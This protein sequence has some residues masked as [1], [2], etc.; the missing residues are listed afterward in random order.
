MSRVFPVRKSYWHYFLPLLILL[1]LTLPSLGPLLAPGLFLTQDGNNLLIRFAQFHLA[2]R[3]GQIPPRWA[4]TLNQG[5][6]YPVLIFYYPGSY[7]ASEVFHLVGF[8][9][10][11]SFKLVAGLTVILSGLFMFFWQL[12]LWRSK[13]LAVT[14]A[15]LYI[16]VPYRFIDLY[17]RGNVAESLVFVFLPLLFWSV[18]LEGLISLVVGGLSFGAIILSHNSIAIVTLPFFLAFIFWSGFFTKKP[19]KIFFDLG[20]VLIGL[21]LSAFFWIPAIFEKGLTKLDEIVITNFFDHF[22]SIQQILHSKVGSAGSMSFEAGLGL[23]TV[24]LLALIFGFRSRKNLTVR[25]KSYLG[26]FWVAFAVSTFLT[27]PYSRSVWQFMKVYN[28]V[29]FPWRLLFFSTF[30]GASLSSLVLLLI[31]SDRVRLGVAMFLMGISFLTSY[32]FVRVLPERKT[33][34][35]FFLTSPATTLN[36]NEVSPKWMVKQPNKY[37]YEKISPGGS[38]KVESSLIKSNYYLFEI[39]A[40]SQS[41]L[42]VNTLYFPGWLVKV[43]GKNQTISYD[44]DYGLIQF[45]VEPGK[46]RIEVSFRETALRMFSDYISVVSALFLV[47]LTVIYIRKVKT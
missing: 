16:W 26:F 40:K 4:P 14:S 3:D 22:L 45:P 11:N 23:L 18:K 7:I 32:R 2:L 27:T 42:T 33:D 34:D 38:I 15:F 21:A 36:D 6:G 44:N 13:L 29:Q 28:L 47:I 46:H 41:I 39:G 10:I 24:F 31:K 37:A 19:R 20:S 5:Y 30:F 1:L 12:D 43:D 25:Q 8:S 35:G 9:L 17:V